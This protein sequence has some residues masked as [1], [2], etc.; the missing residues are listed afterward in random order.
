MEQK[1][2]DPS[3][4]TTRINPSFNVISTQP[5]LNVQYSGDIQGG[6][7]KREGT[8]RKNARSTGSVSKEK[9]QRDGKD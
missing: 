3:Q 9:D 4:L 1:E 5:F 8:I 2:G 7:K 6:V